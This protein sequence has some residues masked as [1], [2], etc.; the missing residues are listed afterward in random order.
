[1]KLGSSGISIGK[2]IVIFVSALLCW[3][4]VAVADSRWGGDYFPNVKLT[5]Q[6]GKTVLFFDDMIKDKTVVINFI[7]TSC[8]D[9]CPLETAQLTRVQQIMGDRIGKDVFFYSISIDPLNDT[10]PVLKAYREKFGAKWSFLTGNAQEIVQLRKKLGLYISEIQ[11]GSNNHNVSMII[12]NQKTGRWMKRSPFENPYV[13][14]NQIG[15]WLSDWKA[16]PKGEDYAHA[17]K[18]RN[19]STG[20]Q[21]FRTRCITC[22]TLTGNEL[23]GALGPDLLGVTKRRSK[24]WL[25]NWLKA[26]DKMLKNKD[27][28][29]MALLAK[30]NNL[31]MPNMRL[32]QLEARELLTYID[33]ETERL[34]HNDQ[35]P[36]VLDIHHAWVRE[37]LPSST[38]NAGYMTLENHSKEPQ[39]LV[40]IK[41]DAFASVEFHQMTTKDGLMSMQSLPTVKI[42]ANT[43]VSFTPGGKHLMMH[44]PKQDFV[45]GQSIKLTLH[46][47]SGKTQQIKVRVDNR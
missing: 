24:F 20:E 32:N 35:T 15:S 5:D 4:S 38:V 41:T 22:H 16:P 29:A 21:M 34:Q 43:T 47:E 37:A 30:Y 46:F 18:L 40:S 39:T 13:L 12:G 7:Y 36:K 33:E 31:A 1:M 3:I 27:P 10:P 42:P 11:D 26:P 23:A 25:F 8:P 6:D 19:I 2:S 44:Q 14:A 28:I 17:P 45:K 9:T